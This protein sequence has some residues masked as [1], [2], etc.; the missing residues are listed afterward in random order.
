MKTPDDTT[1]DE[2]NR[3]IKK[4][5]HEFVW[6][7]CSFQGFHGMTAP[8]AAYRDTDELIEFIRDQLKR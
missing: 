6:Q 1:E 5:A 4:K 8:L 2:I 3:E 7:H